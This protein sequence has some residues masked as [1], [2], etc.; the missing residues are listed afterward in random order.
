MSGYSGTPLAHKLG[1]RTGTRLHVHAPPQHY[2]QLLAPLPPGVQLSTR[3]SKNTDIIHIFAQRRAA[4]AAA[5]HRALQA[6]RPD[7]VIWVSWPKKSSGVAT[8]I[9]E[10]VI[11]EIALPLTLVDV[12]VCAVDEVWSGLKLVI[13]KSARAQAVPKRD[14]KVRGGRRAAP[15]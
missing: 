12:K 9:T 7:A 2:T 5:L 8:D 13:R 6:M 10:G 1:I 3:P 15:I 4:L 14:A 11:R